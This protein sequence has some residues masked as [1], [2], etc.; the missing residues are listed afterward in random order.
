MCKKIIENMS[1]VNSELKKFLSF[2]FKNLESSYSQNLQDL[3]GIWENRNIKKGYFVEFGALSGINVSNSYLMEKLG[4]DGIVAEPH[5][6]YKDILQKN[7]KCKISNEAVYSVSNQEM[8]FSAVLGYPALSTL[9]ESMPND[10]KINTERRQKVKE[11]KVKTISLNDLLIKFKAPKIIDYISID[12][13]GSELDIL[14]TFNFELYNFRAICIE[15]GTEEK[16]NKIK[17]I[18]NTHGYKRKWTKLSKHDDW[19]VHEKLE[20]NGDSS[21]YSNLE[22]FNNIMVPKAKKRLSKEVSYLIKNFS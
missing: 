15:Y 19:Y 9:K 1:N 5:P 7:R 12:T 13:E 4:W 17:K 22:D 14:S 16:R 18:L 21:L 11:F 3:W 2:T 6:G 20:V 10:N 8:I